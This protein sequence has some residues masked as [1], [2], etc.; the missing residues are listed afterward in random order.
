MPRMM[1]A[2]LL[3]FV[4]VAAGAQL[5]KI[6]NQDA[7]SGMRAALDK[8]SQAAVASL[9]KTD[10]FLGNSAVKIGLPESLNQ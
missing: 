2:L 7:S 4:S 3:A 6:S 10:G 1:L 5:S 8:G 9:G